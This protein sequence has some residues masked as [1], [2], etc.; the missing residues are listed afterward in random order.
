MTH[1]AW[2]IKKYTKSMTQ[3]NDTKEWHK[4]HYTKKITRKALHKRMN[5]IALHKN[6]YTKSITQKALHKKLYTKS[7]TQKALHKKHYTELNLQLVEILT[8]LKSYFTYHVN[9]F[10][11]LHHI[12]KS[13]TLKSNSSDMI[14]I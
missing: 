13:I 12:I 3:K 6:N 8:N 9:L 14:M 4:K 10:H 11:S 7:I 2:L 1:Q 5:W